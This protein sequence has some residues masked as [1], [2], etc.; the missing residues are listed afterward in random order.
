MLRFPRVVNASFWLGCVV[1]ALSMG[2]CDKGDVRS[3]ACV[4][5]PTLNSPFGLDSALE[6]QRTSYA[7]VDS[8]FRTNTSNVQV[9]V[10]GVV[11]RFLADD[12][13]GDK[14]QRFILTLPNTRT[15]LIAHN[16]DLANRVPT[17]A[18]N[19]IVYVHGEYEWNAEGGVVHWTHNDPDN[20]HP[21]GWIQFEGDRYW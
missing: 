7:F 16:I 18:L 14:H 5:D 20:I 10:R 13:E 9:L 17:T 6:T 11:S 8:L 4:T 19:K 21:A 1:F 12:L 2:G 3:C 15:L